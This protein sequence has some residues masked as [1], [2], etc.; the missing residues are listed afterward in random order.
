MTEPFWWPV[1]VTWTNDRIH[2]AVLATTRSEADQVA[3]HNWPDAESAVI[4]EETR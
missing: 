3:A 4:T 1:A 2:D